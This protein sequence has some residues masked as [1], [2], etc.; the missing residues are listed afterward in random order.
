[1]IIIISAQNPQLDSFIERRFGRAPWFIKVDTETSNWQALANPGASQS[2]GAGVTAAQFAID[3][4]VDAV[5][6][7]DFG[8]NAANVFRAAKIG[9]HLFTSESETVKQTVIDFQQGKLP[10]M[11]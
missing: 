7:G 8:P 6:S 9:M 11:P 1:M 2:G 3:Q 10:L 5:I 4:K